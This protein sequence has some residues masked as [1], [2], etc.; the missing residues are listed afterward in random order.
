[1][2]WWQGGG[3]HGPPTALSRGAKMAEK[4]KIYNQKYDKLGRLIQVDSLI[5]T[6]FG[7]PRKAWK[8]ISNVFRRVLR[9]IS[10]Q[11][12]ASILGR[13]KPKI[14]S[15]W[16]LAVICVVTSDPP[17]SAQTVFEYSTVRGKDSSYISEISSKFCNF[18]DEAFGTHTTLQFSATKLENTMQFSTTKLENTMR[19]LAI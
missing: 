8:N 11:F 15:I 18:S 2:A 3:G 13:F 9:L 12:C 7:I 17:P 1:M 16:G 6:L 19:N 4:A 5:Q 10:Q 14:S